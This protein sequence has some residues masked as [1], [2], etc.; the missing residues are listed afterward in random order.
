MEKNQ[1]ETGKPSFWKNPVSIVFAIALI[2]LFIVVGLFLGWRSDFGTGIIGLLICAGILNIVL[3]VLAYRTVPKESST[4]ETP[5]G[6]S[7]LSILI[8]MHKKQD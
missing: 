1:S 6:K 3:I 2:D 4:E 7:P 5:K 8:D